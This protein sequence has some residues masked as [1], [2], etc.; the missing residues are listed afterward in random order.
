M[1]MT[2]VAAEEPPKKGGRMGLIL[3][4]AVVA[5]AGGGGFGIGMSGLLPL[6][7]GPTEAEHSPAESH[8]K[9]PKP[10]E[11]IAYYHL[12][13]LVIPLG[14]TAYS[15]Y[16]RTKIYLETNQNQEQIIRNTEP[17][18][19][20]TLNVFL[21]SVDERDVSSVLAMETLRAEMLRRVQLVTGED[22]VHAV[23]IGEFLLR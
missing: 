12:P 9:D 13:E 5:V 21:R 8:A 19:M 4:I 15:R 10:M 20:D 17:R 18:I 14:K 7:F 1:D 22:A 23:L 11:N 16:L 6:P 3:L 2:E